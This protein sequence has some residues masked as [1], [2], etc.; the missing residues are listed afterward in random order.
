MCDEKGTEKKGLIDEIKDVVSHD[1]IPDQP[2]VK[3]NEVEILPEGE[4]VV[5]P[6]HLNELDSQSVKVSIS[7]LEHATGGPERDDPAVND[8]VATL[9]KE[10]IDQ[11]IIEKTVLAAEEGP[12]IYED[13]EAETGF[14][15]EQDDLYHTD[16]VKLAEADAQAEARGFPDSESEEGFYHAMD[17][18]ERH[19][20]RTEIQSLPKLSD[21]KDDVKADHGVIKEAPEVA[22]IHATVAFEPQPEEDT[23]EHEDDL[24]GGL[25]D[26]SALPLSPKK[27]RKTWLQEDTDVT[28]Q[29]FEDLPMPPSDSGIHIKPTDLLQMQLD[30]MTVIGMRKDLEIMN[31]KEKLNESQNAVLVAQTGNVTRDKVIIGYMKKELAEKIALQNEKSRI[32]TETIK[33][34][35]GI[36]ADQWGFDPLTGEVKF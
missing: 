13:G 33:K 16:P 31:M 30:A 34:K 24:A 15:D 28:D 25:D 21:I 22:A 4:C 3:T 29:S 19:D 35:Y 10:E 23:K 8:Y 26:I 2:P 32:H 1:L 11:D 12:V 36:T 20:K 18:E 27:D 6:D 17:R 7:D 5:E 14:Y 9:I